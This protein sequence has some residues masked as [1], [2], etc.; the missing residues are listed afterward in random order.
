MDTTATGRS[1][2]FR[3]IINF[4]LGGMHPATFVE[5]TLESPSV[6][7]V[8]TTLQRVDATMLLTTFAT[9]NPGEGRV[10]NV[11]IEIRPRGSASVRVSPVVEIH[12]EDDFR[13]GHDRQD[14][15][16]HQQENQQ[17]PSG[18][19]SIRQCAACRV[20]GAI[21]RSGRK[22]YEAADISRRGRFRRQAIS[23]IRPLSAGRPNRGTTSE[24][25]RRSRCAD[26]LSAK[27][28]VRM[29]AFSVAGLLAD[30]RQTRR[31]CHSL[32]AQYSAGSRTKRGQAHISGW[33]HLL[34]R[35]MG[36]R[37]KFHS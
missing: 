18:C 13:C 22:Y 2:I 10:D 20:H 17:C 26:C 30:F 27:I 15:G 8:R 25:A 3:C 7:I 31:V 6:P 28:L 24:R 9:R 4:A 36:R 21:F 37:W 29:V 12:S 14:G 19:D 32:C 34:S 1:T 11:L 35:V 5:Q 16:R 33:T 23:R